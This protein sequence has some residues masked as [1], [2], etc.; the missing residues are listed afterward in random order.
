M[1]P[2]LEQRLRDALH[3]DAGR[4]RLLNPGGPPPAGE[5]HFASAPGRSRRLVT[6]A[7]VHRSGVAA[8]DVLFTWDDA[9]RGDPSPLQVSAQRM[10]P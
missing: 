9:S 1:T 8:G 4:A 3:A 5:M 6:V 10:H 7:A 2:D